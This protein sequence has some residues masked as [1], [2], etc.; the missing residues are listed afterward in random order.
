MAKYILQ[1]AGN[2]NW[3]ALFALITFLT[4]FI[5]SIILVL[6]KN[7]STIKHMADLPLEDD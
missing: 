2:I 5:I 6:R 4:I 3:M 7:N 1:N